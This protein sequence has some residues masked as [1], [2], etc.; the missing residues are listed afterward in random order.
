MKIKSIAV[1]FTIV[2]V[3]GCAYY[4]PPTQEERIA[5]YKKNCEV[6]GFKSQTIEN[7][8]CVLEV[9]K[10][11]LSGR[12]YGQSGVGAGNNDARTQQMIDNDRTRRQIMNHGAGGCTPN[13]ST[14]G[15]L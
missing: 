2:F 10:S 15:C 12:S 5:Q 1:V 3:S 8:N 7:A 11:Y 6:M 9:E 4:F 13:F 14:G